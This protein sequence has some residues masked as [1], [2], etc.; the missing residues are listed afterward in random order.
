MMLILLDCRPLQQDPDSER[1]RFIIACVRLLS[2][3]FEWLFLADPL[4]ETSWLPSGVGYRLLTRRSLPGKGGWRWWYDWQLP[5][6]A[7]RYRPDLVMTTGGITAAR[8]R[9]PQCVWMPGNADGE[10]PVKKRYAGIYRKRLTGSLRQ[11]RTIFSFSVRE[12]DYLVSRAAGEAVAGKIIVVSPAAGEY[13]LCLPDEKEKIKER[14]TAGKEY[15]FTAAAGAGLAE[16]ILLLKAFSLFKKRQR[17]NMQLVLTGKDPASDK[18]LAERLETYK[19]REDIHWAGVLPEADE[20]RLAGAS[21]AIVQP[22]DGD[23]L[24]IGVL[25]GWKTGVPVITTDTGHLSEIA[26]EAVLYAG[27]GDPS[28]L[29]GQLMLIYKDEGLRSDLI[30]KGRVRGASY[31]WQRCAAEVRTGIM[32]ALR[33]F[34]ADIGKSAINN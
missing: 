21:Y 12:K 14:Y 9:I 24:G 31:S 15:F 18:E 32:E 26:G 16:I 6:T 22:F 25:D 1:S 11:A 23:S 27:E 33:G 8:I 34:N 17:S 7:R 3:G 13:P 20:F 30:G 10:R 5:L 28:A 29:A 2:E 4:L 19:Y